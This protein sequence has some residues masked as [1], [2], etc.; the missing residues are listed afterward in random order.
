MSESTTLGSNRLHLLSF[1][2]DKWSS[3]GEQEINCPMHRAR[4]RKSPPRISRN[5]THQNSN[6]RSLEANEDFGIRQTI[7]FGF[8]WICEIRGWTTIELAKMF[9]MTVIRK[10]V[11]LRTQT[12]NRS[13]NTPFGMTMKTPTE[14]KE[15]RRV[16]LQRLDVNQL[17]QI[18]PRDQWTKGMIAGILNAEFPALI[19]P[20]STPIKPGEYD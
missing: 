5:H 19:P 18:C 9:V 17:A 16:E 13:D 8:V 2:N 20:P 15:E 7:P 6:E 11:T 10:D 4:T 12:R 3:L 1:V 14:Q